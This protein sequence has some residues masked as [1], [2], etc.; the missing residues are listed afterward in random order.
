[1][2]I[3]LGERI[4]FYMVDSAPAPANISIT[5]MLT[6]DRFAVANILVNIL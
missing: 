6:R 5:Q 4:I 3:K 1:M 2:V